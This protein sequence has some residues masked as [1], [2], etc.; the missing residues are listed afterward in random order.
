MNN[1]TKEIAK[2]LDIPMVLALCVQDRM[3]IDFSECTQD[4]FDREAKLVYFVL[5]GLKH[6]K[7]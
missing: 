7:A 6:G 2:L 1:Y 4:E 5:T 3:E